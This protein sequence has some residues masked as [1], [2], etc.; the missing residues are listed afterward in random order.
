MP[1]SGMPPRKYPLTDLRR[2]FTQH[3][4]SRLGRRY[5]CGSQ[6]DS[7]TYQQ[8]PCRPKWVISVDF[9]LISFPEPHKVN[10]NLQG[11]ENSSEHQADLQQL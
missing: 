10:Q 2:S 9:D 7:R 8:L 4:D 6:E 5:N 11:V 3:V 1:D